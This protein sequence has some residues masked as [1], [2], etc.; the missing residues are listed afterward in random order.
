MFAINLASTSQ[1]SEQLI[2]QHHLPLDLDDSPIHGGWN[3][4][5][6]KGLEL[7]SLVSKITKKRI[8]DDFSEAS[9][10]LDGF[11]HSKMN[12]QLNR[13]L[14]LTEFIDCLEKSETMSLE[15]IADSFDC[16]N[17]KLVSI[18]MLWSSDES[19][20]TPKASFSSMN[21]EKFNFFPESELLAIQQFAL[22][23]SKDT[24]QS[25]IRLANITIQLTIGCLRDSLHGTTQSFSQAEEHVLIAVCSIIAS[26]V[27]SNC[28][29][30]L[31]S[32]VMKIITEIS[33]FVKQS[34]EAIKSREASRQIHVSQDLW[35]I[36]SIRPIDTS[37]ELQSQDLSDHNAIQVGDY[38]PVS[39]ICSVALETCQ[40]VADQLIQSITGEFKTQSSDFSHALAQAF[41]VIQMY[42]ALKKNKFAPFLISAVINVLDRCSAISESDMQIRKYLNSCIEKCRHLVSIGDANSSI[43]MEMLFEI[44]EGDFKKMFESY[45]N[46]VLNNLLLLIII[47]SAAQSFEDA[48]HDDSHVNS[49]LEKVSK[50]HGILGSWVLLRICRD[51]YKRKTFHNQNPTIFTLA[52]NG[53]QDYLQNLL[54][55]VVKEVIEECIPNL[56]FVPKNKSEEV[57]DERSRGFAVD[58][59]D[60]PLS[61]ISFSR[62]FNNHYFFSQPGTPALS[63]CSETLCD[64]GI[65]EGGK[66]SNRT[67]SDAAEPIY[68]MTA[69][70]NQINTYT[71]EKIF[72]TI[73]SL[74]ILDIDGKKTTA[75]SIGSLLNLLRVAQDSLKYKLDSND[76]SIIEESKWTFDFMANHVLSTPLHAESIISNT[77]EWLGSIKLF[78]LSKRRG[79]CLFF[80]A[81]N[82]LLESLRS[83]ENIFEGMESNENDGK[84]ILTPSGPGESAINILINTS[85]SFLLLQVYLT[86]DPKCIKRF[87]TVQRNTIESVAIELSKNDASG[88]RLSTKMLNCIVMSLARFNLFVLSRFKKIQFLPFPL[89][90]ELDGW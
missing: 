66:S 20:R 45:D 33:E 40:V 14:E 15:V 31:N 22:I 4:F 13:L 24:L 6:Q 53:D 29:D 75:K 74:I 17:R 81:V 70:E 83:L 62:P 79:P 9:N 82:C 73:E 41:L 80:M 55:E 12:Q 8:D 5:C 18:G 48:G 42:P 32:Q 76:K 84:H 52:I 35:P 21:F 25:L 34:S 37:G 60:S 72:G 57:L 59:C 51:K 26:K 61:D 44:T 87:R 54:F 11:S 3:I 1:S 67:S 86:N 30:S 89:T 36:S 38:N 10:T 58:N 68:T 46:D 64:S 39:R 2:D 78:E 19:I 50:V 7:S 43:S 56:N 49:P 27:A 77:E 85:I 23:F 63:S 47:K 88:S 69:L 90:I 65:S 28:N 16:L 71:L